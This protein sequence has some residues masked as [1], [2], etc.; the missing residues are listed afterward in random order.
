MSIFQR[1][2]YHLPHFCPTFAPQTGYLWS[3]TFCS[4][5]RGPNLNSCASLS[6]SLS[7]PE[8]SDQQWKLCLVVAFSQW[9][10]GPNALH[11]SKLYWCQCILIRNKCSWTKFDVILLSPSFLLAC[12]FSECSA[13]S[14]VVS[15]TVFPCFHILAPPQQDLTRHSLHVISHP[16][17]WPCVNIHL[18]LFWRK[19]WFVLTLR[20]FL[21]NYV[22]NHF[23]STLYTLN[24][25]SKATTEWKKNSV[26][27]S[28]RGSSNFY[29]FLLTVSV[30]C[31]YSSST[32]NS[33]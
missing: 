15:F 1:Y 13:L 23:T 14:V 2:W 25:L 9:A 3:I 27:N 7:L 12:Q 24:S 31:K 10:Y 19:L 22:W 21:I 32:N 17:P 6:L 20:F 5:F 18:L 4:R 29:F 16:W 33:L 28:T 30:L 11:N 8:K 26:N